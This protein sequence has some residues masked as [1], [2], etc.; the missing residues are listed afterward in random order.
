MSDVGRGEGIS[1]WGFRI[2]EWGEGQEAADEGMGGVIVGAT[3][4]RDSLEDSL[5]PGV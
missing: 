1:E 3:Y 4:P 2:S 5:I